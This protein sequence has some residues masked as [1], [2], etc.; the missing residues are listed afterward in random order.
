MMRILT[1]QLTPRNENRRHAKVQLLIARLSYHLFLFT[2]LVVV[3]DLQSSRL[4]YIC[5]AVTSICSLLL[6]IAKVIRIFI[7][8]VRLTAPIMQ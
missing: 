4:L 8:A 7:G 5:R 3:V 2:D 6:I 1:R